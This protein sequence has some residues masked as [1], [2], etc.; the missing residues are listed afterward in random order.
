MKILLAAA[1]FAS[2]M[3]GLQR[4][5]LNVARCLLLDPEVS[6]LHLVFAPWQRH[7]VQDAGLRSDPRLVTHIAKM[8]KSSLSRNLWYYREL[9]ELAARLGVDLVHFSY[10]MP[11]NRAVFSC[12]TMVTLHDLYAYEIPMNFGFPKFIFN[13]MVLRQCLRKVDAV[14]CVSD[15]TL[16]RLRQYAPPSVWRKALRI[17]NCV[18]AD[19]IVGA[20]TPIQGWQGKSFLL[21][22]AQHRRN[23]N[24]PLLL[25]SFHRLLRSGQIPADMKLLVIGIAGPET[26]KIRRLVSTLGLAGST[27]FREG[28]SESE[29]QWCYAQCEAVVCPSVTEGFGLPIVEALL[30]GCRV[31]CSDIPVFREVGDGH[32]RFVALD[33]NAE[34]ALA[35]AIV[36]ALIDPK[37][38]Q[39][40]LQQFSAPVLAKQY[41]SL[42]RRLI[43]SPSPSRNA[44]VAASINA[45]TSERLPL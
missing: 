27:S 2:K 5:A 29:L 42:Y 22:V 33:G 13:R 9:P 25:Q 10:P 32:C 28:V 3:S 43:T 19:P 14:A 24:I 21:S 23:K 4:H 11:V 34:E 8:D 44:G 40:E 36:A 37:G 35:A 1:S 45:A 15:T 41:T 20:E 39:M 31:V 38:P 7:F 16:L 30:A 26:D 12:P 6:T 17:Y 18:E